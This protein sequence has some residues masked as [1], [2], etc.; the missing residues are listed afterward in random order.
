MLS[1]ARRSLLAGSSST[2]T[3]LDRHHRLAATLVSHCAQQAQQQAFS[4][5]ANA[6]YP[7]RHRLS[8][9]QWM[10]R[11]DK[12]EKRRK[13]REARKVRQVHKEFVHAE[14][15]M[16]RRQEVEEKQEMGEEI[17]RTVAPL[18][19]EELE[20]VYKGLI[21]A[22]PEDLAPLLIPPSNIPALPDPAVESRV[23]RDRV[24]QIAERLQEFEAELAE[25]TKQLA[26]PEE[27]EG[28]P[29]PSLAA[30]LRRSRAEN[31]AELALAQMQPSLPLVPTTTS[32]R[33]LIDYLETITPEDE[34][35][36]RQDAELAE[37][38]RGLLSRAEWSDLVLASAL[39]GDREGVF[40]AL[41]LMNRTTPISEGKVLE[42]ALAIY[43]AQGQPQEALALAKFA[44]E[45][46]LPISL[47][48]HHQLLTSLL[49]SHPE[50]AL[51]HLKAMEAA[52]YTPLRET[53]TAVT[54][55]L[56]SSSSPNLVREGWDLYSHSRLVAYPIPDVPMF[57]TVIQACARGDHPAPERAI[58]LFT[59]MTDD[60]G[61]PPSELAY[62]GVIRA[63]ARDGTREYYHEALRFM[64]RMLDD[65][66]KPSRHTFHAVL[67]GAKKHGDL[68]RARWMLIK[69]VGVG[70]D[71][72]PN[73]ATLALVLQAY[74]WYRPVGKED[75]KAK[76]AQ[77]PPAKQDADARGD[78][79]SAIETVEGVVEVDGEV[80]PEDDPANLSAA[81]APSTGSP[82]AAQIVE[83]L[84]E[85]SL[86]YPGPLP[87]TSAET[88]AEA[89]KLMLQVVDASV[90]D[91]TTPAPPS[92]SESR[93][94]STMFPLVEPTSFLLNS[95]LI[96]LARHGPFAAATNFFAA[97][98]DRT[99]VVKSRHS[100][101]VLMQRIEL[102][103][104]DK[105]AV[106]AAKKLW[107]EWLTW[108]ETPLPPFSPEEYEGESAETARDRRLREEEK[109][110]RERRN[111]ENVRAMWG[112]LIRVLARAYRVDE[113]LSV[114][115]RFFQTFSPYVVREPLTPAQQQPADALPLPSTRNP[116]LPK[117]PIRI[118]SSQ[119]PETAPSFDRHRAPYLRFQDL[120]VLHQRCV[121]LEDKKGMAVVKAITAAYEGAL[122]RVRKKEL[123]A[124]RRLD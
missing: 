68:A 30:R 24:E 106:E 27:E 36:A 102:L 67:E 105:Q 57:S 33:A 21:L 107:E 116:H 13:I 81:P 82:S 70:G 95:Y 46:R 91:A 63:C 44:R 50:L 5:S 48:A 49:P 90:L 74:A 121:E 117:V 12:L 43:A 89:R 2:A 32:A 23:R 53:Y 15:A 60:N 80:H 37:L 85:E 84:G 101:S 41:Q 38:P 20:A 59:E 115:K 3:L 39:D 58:D 65:N 54:K 86:F 9:E 108:S 118:S 19:P 104:N 51:R 75:G 40:K 6:A 83:L 25:E 110:A 31:A 47:I 52:G 55:R 10:E 18:S 69:M 66:V 124:E 112:G 8:K 14:V 94:S 72:A 123:E 87:T 73:D 100:F 93:P 77:V 62:N 26:A 71:V 42:N 45:N 79:S 7:L 114:L 119:Y 16:K 28:E 76:E 1:A 34:P 111:G 22:P 122:W 103:E 98:Y 4:T 96:V 92:L 113:A 120:R 109:W 97:V 78:G 11:K 88:L 29:R 17:V 64:R 35:V 99:G 61:L 56:V